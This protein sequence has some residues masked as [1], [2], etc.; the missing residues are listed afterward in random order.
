[1][2]RY[3]LTPIID[4]F[5]LKL[6]SERLCCE[7]LNELEVFRERMQSLHPRLLPMFKAS[8]LLS[9]DEEICGSDVLELQWSGENDLVFDG[10]PFHLSHCAEAFLDRLLSTK[11]AASML[12]LGTDEMLS[13]W[14]WS[15]IQLQW[16]YK[17]IGWLQ[18]D[19]EVV[20]LRED[21]V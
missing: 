12:I 6:G 5:P 21:G 2:P 13:S 8:L 18:Q 11:E 9:D 4:R 14:E 10:A 3:W 7:P 20:L 16:L 17:W 1:M 15:T 19:R